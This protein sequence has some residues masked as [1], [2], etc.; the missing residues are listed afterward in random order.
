MP[1]TGTGTGIQNANDVFFS[2]LSNNDVLRYNGATFKWNN[3][4]MSVS[5]TDIANDAVTE[6]KLAVSNSPTSG[7]VL[8]WNGSALSWVSQGSGSVGTDSIWDTK[9]DLAVATGSNTAARLAVGTDGTVLTADSSQ[10][11]GVRWA[12]PGASSGSVTEV[13]VAADDAPTTVKN[14]ADYVCDG[15]A[16]QVE[17]NLAIDAAFQTAAAGPRVGVVLVG[18]FFNISA[19]IIMK[20]GITLRGLGMDTILRS[21]SMGA[22]T[23]MIE[24][25]DKNHHMT[26]IRDLTL[27]G[28]YAAGG[29]SNGIHFLNSDGGG[30]GN[31]GT[32]NPASSPDSS[33]RIHNLFVR[34]FTTGTRH[35]I[36]MDDN[37]RGAM[38]SMVRVAD[39]S[40]NGF[41]MNGSSD[42]KYSS[43]T[44]IGCNVGWYVGGASNQFVACKSSYSDAEG[45]NLASSRAHLTGCHSQD[46]GTEGYILSGVDPSLTG[47]VADSNSRLSGTAYALAVSSS[48]P[49]IEGIHIYDRGQTPGSPQN[50]G[51]DFTGATHVFATGSIRLGSGSSYTSGTPTG[52]ARLW[53]VGSSSLYSLG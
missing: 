11:S 39:C 41:Y 18:Q 35:G 42:G 6:P 25:A 24:L 8:S 36:Y 47:C 12:S 5:T 13:V 27:Y 49:M 53:Q 23:S 34:A 17:I 33:H 4:A 44:A 43:C 14:S 38:I 45:W 2:G 48:R 1:F 28:N 19:A 37:V 20:A 3:V 32:Y 10:S 22:G 29:S 21:I 31:M 52:Y 50:R 9:G 30:D 51:I 26:T 46:S 15:T 40:G 7:Y 16:D